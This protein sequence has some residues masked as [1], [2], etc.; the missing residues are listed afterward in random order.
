MDAQALSLLSHSSN[1]LGSPRV[2]AF[3]AL[4]VTM[5]LTPAVVDP[6]IKH[7]LID[8]RRSEFAWG[9]SAKH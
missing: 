5:Q 6:L 3:L 2:V 7:D 9:F 1:S 4:D 8:E